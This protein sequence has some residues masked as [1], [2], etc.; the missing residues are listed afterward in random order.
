MRFFA[1]EFSKRSMGLLILG[2]LSSIP[3]ILIGDNSLKTNQL[4]KENAGPK[5]RDQVPENDRW[6]VSALYPD[7]QLWAQEFQ[8]VQGE[9]KNP[10]WP[11]M[12]QYQGRLKD[13]SV[14]AAFFDFY[15]TLDRKLSKLYTYAHLRM[16]EDL[17]NDSIKT[18]FGKITSL[19][20]DFGLESSWIKP[21]ILGLSEADYQNLLHHAALK[22][23][24]LYLE[25]MGRMR[26]HTLSP[27]ME[28]LVALSGQALDTSHRAFGAL[29]NAD[30]TF[31]P[32]LD[33]EGVERPL[34]NGTYGLYMRNEDRT[35]RKNA[36]L[37]LH[38][39]YASHVN[40]LCELLQGQM[41]THL[42][43]AKAYKFSSCLEAALYPHAIDPSVY[44]NLITS[45]RKHLPQM[46]EYIAFRKKQMGLDQIHLYDLNVPLVSE[47]QIDMTYEEAC[48]AVV[49]SV[50]PLGSEY[51][52]TLKQG[53]TEDRWVDVFENARKRS[54]AYSSGCYDSMPYILMNY[55]GTFSD[56]TTL[57]HEAGHSMHS[58]LSRKSQPY[59]YSSYSIFVAEVASTFNEQL[60][61]R[62]MKQKAK[63]KEEM[64]YLINDE[65][66]RIRNTIFR[67]TMFAEFELQ[68]HKWV[69]EG[70]PF[71]PAL[72]KEKYLQLVREYYGPDLVIDSEA[73]VEWSRIPHF[74][75]D[76]YVYQYATGLSAALALNQKAVASTSARDKYLKFLSSGSRG[77][78]LDLLKE[79]GVDMR[80]TEPVD[81]ALNHFGSL[82][83]ELRGLLKK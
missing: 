51:Q 82:V 50:A 59:I 40:S 16:D 39:G 1:N 23:Y 81:M 68:L 76:F 80:S 53:L 25:K 22:D 11:Q 71:T 8:S 57:A 2:V 33:S 73:E 61:L 19:L 47:V 45:V 69:E 64:A 26:P 27:E 42:F 77:Y 15:T 60:L 6:N 18:D 24:R 83:S 46:H 34:S 37:N 55:H 9:E 58:F 5:L 65:I 56:V 70:V 63:N 13:P 4:K 74:Y 12:K 66:E 10:R 41:Q 3:S 75:Y 38:Q 35:L 52:N 49:A 62:L 79:A 14:A 20:H 78:P 43:L 17:G 36:F 29:T 28:S 54:G 67:Q 32:A 7:V 48:Q 31:R 44:S 30:F 72:L 21:E